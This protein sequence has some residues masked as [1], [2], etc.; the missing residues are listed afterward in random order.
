VI[1]IDRWYNRRVAPCRHALGPRTSVIATGVGDYLPFPDT[2]LVPVQRALRGRPV[3]LRDADGVLGF[4]DLVRRNRPSPEEKLGAERLPALASRLGEITQRQLVVN[5]F[6]LRLWLPDVVAGDERVVLGVPLSSTL[7]VVWVL[8]SV[9][10]AATMVLVDERRAAMRQRL[11]VRARPT[12]LPV[13][14]ELVDDLLRSSRRRTRMSSVRIAVTRDALSP[15][16]RRAL[17]ELTDKGRIRRAWGVFDLLTHADPVYGRYEHGTVGLPLP[18][19]AVVVADPTDPRQPMPL[20]HRGR[21]WMRGP[22]LRSDTWVDAGVDA[23]LHRT[24]YL[25]VHDD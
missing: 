12:I 24:G 14:D 6:Q 2:V 1:V 3:R 19:T 9:L 23:T 10:A 20:G 16:R 25:T 11:A 7:G 8:T 17:E 18:D 22:Q 13:D 15:E 21:L 4:A 5:S